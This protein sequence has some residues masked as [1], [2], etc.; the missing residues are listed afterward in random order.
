MSSE[1]EKYKTVLNALI[2][3]NYH[4]INDVYL[5]MFIS[6]ISGKNGQGRR[7]NLL[8]IVDFGLISDYFLF[9]FRFDS[10]FL[11]D[12]TICNFNKQIK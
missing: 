3:Q 6:H 4:V 5:D 2:Q 10:F 8:S 9:M 11:L 7:L 12:Q 1:S